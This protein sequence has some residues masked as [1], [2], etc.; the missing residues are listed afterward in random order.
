MN[1]AQTKQSF[2]EPLLNALG[3]DTSDY[4]ETSMEEN[5][6]LIGRVDYALKINGVSRIYVEA[7][8]LS[9]DLNNPDYIKK[10]VT[11]AYSK[12][13]NWA[14]LTNFAEIH[15]FNVNESRDKSPIRFSFEDYECDFDRLWLLSKVSISDGLLNKEAVKWGFIAQPIPITSWWKRNSAARNRAFITC[16]SSLRIILLK[17]PSAGFCRNTAIMKT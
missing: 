13:I 16:P 2:I 9:A 17:K 1:E 3:W 4:K 12:G 11:Y 10:T 8:K 15:L 5:V 14:L 6:P 7:K